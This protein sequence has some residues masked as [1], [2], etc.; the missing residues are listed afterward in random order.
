MRKIIY[1]SFLILAS[2]TRTQ[3]NEKKSRIEIIQDLRIQAITNGDDYSYGTYIDFVNQENKYY[4]ML[5]ISLIMNHRYK[6]EKSYYQIYRAIVS[7]NNN[8]PYHPKQLEY[9]QEIDRNY[10][11]YYLKEGAK[12]NDIACQTTLEKIY[13]NGYGVKVDSKKSD[14]LYTIL[15]NNK[16]F[17]DFYRK[18]RENKKN[19]DEIGNG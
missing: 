12:R 10:A 9:V 8:S 7:M 4:D 1:I 16:A 15:E 5:T 18:N 2:C 13:R 11:L 14:S 6:N 3:N 17:G 19:V